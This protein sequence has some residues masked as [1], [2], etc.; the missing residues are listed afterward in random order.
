MRKYIILFVSCAIIVPVFAGCKKSIPAECNTK[1]RE[2]KVDK[3]I[4]ADKK[5]VGFSFV[6]AC[7]A[8]CASGTIWGTDTYTTDS[9]VCLAGIHAGIIKADKGGEIKVNMVK[10]LDKYAGSERNGVKTSDWNTSWGHT[11]FSVSAK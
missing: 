4:T 9:S 5:E 7:P 8:N 6:V 10:G 2:I 1:L 3:D 11:A